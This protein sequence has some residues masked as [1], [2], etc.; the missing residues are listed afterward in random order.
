VENRDTAKVSAVPFGLVFS[1]F[2]V[3]RLKEWAHEGN[4]VHRANNRALE[5][6]ILD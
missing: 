6:V 5:V 2:G 3:H 1:E 4:L